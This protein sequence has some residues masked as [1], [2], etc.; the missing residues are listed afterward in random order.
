LIKLIE[1]INSLGIVPVVAIEDSEKAP[2]L[3][4]ALVAG[5][6]PC[7]EITFRTQAAGEAI[8]SMSR[9]YPEMLIGAGTVLTVAQAEQALACGAKFVVMPG[10]DD[11]VVDYCLKE[12]VPIV[13]GIATPTEINMALKKGLEVL[14]FFPAEVMGGVNMLKAISGPYPNVKFIPTGGIDAGNLKDYLSLPQVIACGG[15]WMVAK[16]LINAGDFDAITRI[17]REA[18]TLVSEI[19]R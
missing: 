1:Q 19:R 3:G 10:Y 6:L 9:S 18:V 11:E 16:K 7:A 13:P 17:T 15:S 4:K 2:S 5:G 14:K 12:E 8:R